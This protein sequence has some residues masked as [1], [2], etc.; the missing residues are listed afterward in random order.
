[1]E[2]AAAVRMLNGIFGDGF[3]ANFTRSLVAS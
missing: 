3:I 1:M 2:E